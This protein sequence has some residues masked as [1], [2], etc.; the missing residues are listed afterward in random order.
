MY[1]AYPCYDEEIISR[2]TGW[3]SVKKR[4]NSTTYEKRRVGSS[5]HSRM[6]YPNSRLEGGGKFSFFAQT[7]GQPSA[8]GPTTSKR[9]EAGEEEKGNASL[10]HQMAWVSSRCLRRKIHF[11]AQA[12]VI[13]RIGPDAVRARESHSPSA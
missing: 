3:N 6:T 13:L 1:C 11:F 12:N 4:R 5:S 9:E 8:I 2:P 7:N 10:I